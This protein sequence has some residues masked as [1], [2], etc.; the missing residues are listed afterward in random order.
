MKNAFNDCNHTSFHDRVAKNFPEIAPWVY[1]CYCQ[2]AEL[3]F[4]RRHILASTG[5][6][7][8]DPLDPLLFS[9]V[10]VQ[11]LGSTSFAN[12]CS[13]SLWC[14]TMVPFIGPRSLLHDILSC[15]AKFG[16]RFSLHI[17][18][19]MCEL[20]WPCGDSIFLQL[21]NALTLTVMV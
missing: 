1:W 20:Y 15:F 4:G 18:L 5:G 14:L 12:T 6:Q 3:R 9:F 19:S 16:P 21:S 13:L 2:P 10:L 11:F 7:Q 8:G 17:N